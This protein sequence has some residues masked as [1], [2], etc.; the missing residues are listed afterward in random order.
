VTLPSGSHP[1]GL[2]V[3][4]D[5]THVYVTSTMADGSTGV[6]AF[7]VSSS[8]A[9]AITN[10]SGTATGL[11]VSPDNSKLYIATNNATNST[12]TVINTS[13]RTV[14]GSYAV[15]GVVAGVAVSND[16]ST[17]VVND[18]NGN[19]TTLDAATGATLST[20][21]TRALSTA[22]SQLPGLAI[23][24][25]GTK[26]FVTDSGQNTV[27][28]LTLTSAGA[29]AGQGWST[30]GQPP[31]NVVITVNNPTAAIGQ[32]SGSVAA[33]DPQGQALSYTVSSAATKGTVNMSSATGTFTYVPTVASRYAAAATT[34]PTTDTFTVS[35]A[36]TAG[37]ATRQTVTVT[38]AP[39]SSSAVSIDQR[40]TS[41]AMNVQ[42]M[43]YYTPAQTNAALDLLKADG[44]TTIRI[45]VPWAA[46]EPS[47][48]VY[49]WTAV[50][51]M[52]TA[53]NQRGMQINAV[54]DS[55]PSWALAGGLPISGEPSPTYFAAFANTVATR[56]S[57][58][59]S[60]YE[61]YNEVNAVNFWTPAPNAAQY[62][63]LLKA[64]YPVI[65]AA[66]PNAEVIA[67]GLA[68]V[69]TVGNVTI[70]PSTYLQQ[71]YAAGAQGYFDAVAYHPY[72]YTT[73]FS[74]GKY[75]TSPIK[76]VAAMYALMVANGDGS[77]QIWATE[78]GEPSSIVSEQSQATYIND[79]LTTWRSLPYPGPAFID[80]LQDYSSSDKY[81]SSMG[82]YRSD[83]TPKPAVATIE[84][85]IQQNQ[86]IIAAEKSQSAA[87]AQSA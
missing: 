43:Y 2:T 86:A 15:S 77:K 68:S 31:T 25:D 74:A 11:A 52:V 61:I 75:S 36:D 12:V 5:K 18:T 4:P 32:V 85:V 33:T 26:F 46:V 84:E 82:V 73:E 53:A 62:T 8:S 71:M 50:D 57:G 10:L 70:A 42:E 24:P 9:T 83:W 69:V 40:S 60:S 48:G 13:K 23:S 54:L 67:A 51:Q 14:I 58:K 19:V 44:I 64:A 45:V 3:S 35:I 80:T 39:A 30:V 34:A 20:T 72:N 37:N 76:Q 59:I 21:S 16:G 6:S 28:V 66:D 63:A 27:G 87:A 29:S 22:E 79:F 41:V 1:T 56:Y 38:V 65:K 7:A 49:K 78:Y 47:N 17:L 55:T 81:S